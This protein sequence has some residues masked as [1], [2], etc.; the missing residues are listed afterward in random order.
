MISAASAFPRTRWLAPFRY[1]GKT[2]IESFNNYRV[3]EHGLRK[4]IACVIDSVNKCISQTVYKEHK[5]IHIVTYIIHCIYTLYVIS[6]FLLY[7]KWSYFA[8]SVR[9]VVIILYTHYFNTLKFFLNNY[10]VRS[11]RFFTKIFE[12]IEC[13][14]DENHFSQRLYKFLRW[15]N[16]KWSWTPERIDD[17]VHR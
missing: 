12:M 5:H 11:C 8:W 9:Y 4:L 16:I 15:S 14:T 2:S 1:Q 7:F 10:S 13:I 3:N 6:N 17:I